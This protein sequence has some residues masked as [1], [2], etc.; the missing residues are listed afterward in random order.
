MSTVK[1]MYLSSWINEVKKFQN[2]PQYEQD[3]LCSYIQCEGGCNM[4]KDI[5]KITDD[6]IIENITIT[7]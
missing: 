7:T 5:S 4:C 3:K 2:L 1:K 6:Q